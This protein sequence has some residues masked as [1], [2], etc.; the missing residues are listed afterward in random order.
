[1]SSQATLFTDLKHPKS[2]IFPIFSPYSGDAGKSE[3]SGNELIR[4]AASITTSAPCKGNMTDLPGG[5][6]IICRPKRARNDLLCFDRFYI[7]QPDGI[8]VFSGRF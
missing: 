7:L 3:N 5:T 2:R 4:R 6:L 8:L 1:M